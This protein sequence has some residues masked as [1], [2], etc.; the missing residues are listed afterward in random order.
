MCDNALRAAATRV[1]RYYLSRGYVGRITSANR[2]N[3]LLV[4][5]FKRLRAVRTLKGITSL[6]ARLLEVD[7][8]AAKAAISN[9][10]LVV[11]H[12]LI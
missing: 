5:G 1:E 4:D 11:C 8:Q 6:Q 10:N 9:L 2:M 3:V 7:E 12:S